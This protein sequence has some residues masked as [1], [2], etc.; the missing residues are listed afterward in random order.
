MNL[1]LIKEK[2]LE[3]FSKHNL[4]LYE[5]L[6][7]KM[8][9]EKI[10]TILIDGQISHEELEGIHMEVL[11]AIDEQLPD[12]YYLQL[13]TVGIEKELRNLDEVI[14]H[15]GG[16]AYIESNLFMG[17]ATID[18]VNDNII[19]ISF[20]IKGRPKK[21]SLP[22]QDIRFIRQAVKF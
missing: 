17:E 11:E 13:S 5:I 2:V 22:Y 15:T 1:I 16:F 3:I 19:N 12:D 10:L 20:F 4:V 7:E 21:L 6:Q 9:K 8:G 14:A 18:S